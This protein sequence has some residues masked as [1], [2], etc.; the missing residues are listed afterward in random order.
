MQPC[1]PAVF[2][3]A[4]F[5]ALLVLDLIAKNYKDVGFHVAGGIFSVIGLY[6][7]CEL[8]GE[9]AAW[10]LLGI[11]F[12]VLLVGLVMIWKDSQKEVS[13]ELPVTEQQDS[14]VADCPCPYC[15]MCPCHCRR[16]RSCGGGSVNVPRAPSEAPAPPSV[17]NIPQRPP[18]PFGCPAKTA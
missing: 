18:A 2:T 1:I 3:A 13:P 16:W 14:G 8:A 12:V 10:I 6:T 9:T 11:P 17:Q 15:N 5:T 7:A 4:L